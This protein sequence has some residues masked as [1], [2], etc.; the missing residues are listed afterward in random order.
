MTWSVMVSSSQPSS[1]SGTSMGQGW[2]V[3][4]MSGS[5]AWIARLVC[6]RIDGRPG[7]DDADV[8]IARGRRRR[9]RAGLDDA[10]DGH[11][12]LFLELRHGERRG[13][14]ARDDD[15]LRPLGQQQSGD[16]DGVSLDGLLA[17]APVGDARGVADVKDVLRGHQLAQ[18]RGNGKPAYARSRNT[19]SGPLPR[20]SCSAA[21]AGGGMRLIGAGLCGVL[22][23]LPRGGGA[24]HWT[25]GD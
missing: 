22:G 14:I 23:S 5:I 13:G 17:L 25:A 8:P 3:T 7:A 4:R 18:C 24:G 20:S 11:F 16:F 10:D 2:L 21:S 12:Q 6:A 9:S 15:H 1:I 19:P